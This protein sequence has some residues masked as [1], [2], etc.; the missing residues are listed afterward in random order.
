M[1]DLSGVK[2]QGCQEGQI[3]IEAG[4]N[5]CSQRVRHVAMHHLIHLHLSTWA[6]LLARS[7]H[8]A[9]A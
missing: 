3:F 8:N 1:I 4:I 7:V 5:S 6:F 2:G 9:S